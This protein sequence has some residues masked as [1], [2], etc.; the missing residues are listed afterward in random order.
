MRFRFEYPV[1]VDIEY[2]VTN[3]SILAGQ[4]RGHWAHTLRRC[5]RRVL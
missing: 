2:R 4:G 3:R 5:F 1:V